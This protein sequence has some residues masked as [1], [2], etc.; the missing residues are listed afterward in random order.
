MQLNSIEKYYMLNIYYNFDIILIIIHI[1]KENIFK[2]N[3]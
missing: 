3:I 1:F 2:E